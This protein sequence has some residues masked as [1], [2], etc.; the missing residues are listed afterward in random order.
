MA[1]STI[2]ADLHVD[3]AGR[4]VRGR[5][6]SRSMRAMLLIWSVIILGGLAYFIVLGATGH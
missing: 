6:E 3:P 5:V 2:A 1:I 4:T